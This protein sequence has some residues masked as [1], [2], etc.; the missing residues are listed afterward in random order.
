M[1]TQQRT[2]D[3]DGQKMMVWERG[4]VDGIPVVMV[5]GF[6]LDHSMWSNQIDGLDPEGERFRILC[7]DLFGCGESDTIEDGTSMEKIADQLAFMLDQLGISEKV[8]FC[9]LSMGGYV[10]WQFLQRYHDRVS[11]LIACNTR[12]SGD[13]EEAALGRKRMATSVVLMGLQPIA[14]A[15][16]LTLFYSGAERS[17]KDEEKRVL[18]NKAIASTDVQTIA[19]LQ[20]AMAARPD[21]TGF[22]DQ[23]EVPTLVVSGRHDTITP[24]EEMRAMADEIEGSTFVCIENAAHLT[25]LEN[26]QHFN[27][28]VREFLS[29]A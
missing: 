19:K 12:A 22:L 7:P 17:E 28:A 4:P 25:P 13:S 5:H 9:G 29:G 20:L 18:I 10:G 14:D 21:M 16:M 3:V 8:V 15:M 11:H 1:E 6:P 24:V 2:V 23:I 27:Q 26:S